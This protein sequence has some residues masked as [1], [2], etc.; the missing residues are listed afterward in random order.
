MEVSLQN[1]TLESL[2]G[3]IRD[4]PD[5]GDFVGQKIHALRK[6]PLGRLRSEDLRL[7]IE[8]RVSL[9]YLLPLAI[10][11]LRKNLF[12]EGDYYPGDLLQSVLNLNTGFWTNHPQEWRQVH[13]LIRYREFELEDRHIATETFLEL[14]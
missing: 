4:E 13:E 9:P 8:N 14:S 10:E 6:T 11:K 12:E 5:Y 3:E 1:E 7:L 2:E